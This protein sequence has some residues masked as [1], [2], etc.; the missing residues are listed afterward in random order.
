MVGGIS[1]IWAIP[2]KT[3]ARVS[4]QSPSAS[5][6]WFQSERSYKG[7]LPGTVARSSWGT[8]MMPVNNTPLCLQSSE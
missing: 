6:Q 8:V 2:I 5:I 4:W 3:S 1:L 7:R